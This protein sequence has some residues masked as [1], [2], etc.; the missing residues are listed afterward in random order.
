MRRSARRSAPPLTGAF[1]AFEI[2]IGA[3]TAASIAPVMAAAL[4]AALVVRLSGSP[5]YL[6][7][8]PTA[9]AITTTDYFLFASL[10]MLCGL[11][12]IAVMPAVTLTELGSRRLPVPDHFRPVIGGLLL[13]PVAMMTRQALSAGHGA[14]HLNLTM[15]VSLGF[16]ALVFGAKIAASVISL[17]F[18]FR[19]GLFFASLFLGSLLGQIFGPDQP[20]PRRRGGQRQ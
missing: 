6:I 15:Q 1:Y 7:A 16:L 20:D 10:G 9:E 14:L 17:G 18:G 8:L 19:G 11:A 4:A 3:Y 5:A 12:G 2:V 13:I